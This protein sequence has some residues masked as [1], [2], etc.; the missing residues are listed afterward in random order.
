MSEKIHTTAPALP[1]D[2][3]AET[4]R[5][6]AGSGMFDDRELSV[7]ATV[8][9]AIRAATEGNI[10]ARDKLMRDAVEE[11]EASRHLH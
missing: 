10:T 3:D 2:D 7:I 8:L 4:N 5:M 1:V 6:F 9:S 11:Y